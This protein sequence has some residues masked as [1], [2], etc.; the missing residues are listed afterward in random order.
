[1]PQDNTLGAPTEGLGQTVTFAGR[2]GGGVPQ[3]QA[4]QRQAL[5]NNASGGG[6]QLTARA[7]QVPDAQPDP[8]FQVLARLGGEA[9]KPHLEAE[10]TA[11]YVQGMQKAA[12]GQAIQE[13][14]DEQPWFSKLFGSTSLVDGA[15]AYTA[16]AKANSVAVDIESN[17]PELRKLS[18]EEFSKYATSAITKAN[19][20]DA[21][22]D[23][24]LSQQISSTLP[25]V[26]KAQAK[27][28]IRFTQEQYED[29]QES[30]LT[31]GWAG[32]GSVDAAARQPGS[33]TDQRDVG[34][35][36]LQ[37]VQM[38]VKPPEMDAKLHFKLITRTAARA[39]NSGNFAAYRLLKESHKYDELNPEEQGVVERAYSAAS[40]RAKLN[41]PDDVLADVARFSGMADDPQ[42]TEEAIL[43]AAKAI[44][45]RYVQATG[46]YNGLIGNAATV[47]EL[48]QLKANER[49]RVA[50]LAKAAATSKGEDKEILRIQHLDGVAKQFSE[51]DFSSVYRMENKERQDLFD[52]LRLQAQSVPPAE[53]E[54]AEATLN[55]YRASIADVVVD[56]AHKEI[57]ESAIGNAI[58][59]GNADLMATAYGQYYV[60]LLK[61]GGGDKGAVAS[62]YSGEYASFMSKY[63]AI[64]NR[65]G[66]G[67]LWKAAAFDAA[68]QEHT[69]APPAK[70]E[71]EVAS[72]LTTKGFSSLW[73]GHAANLVTGDY[74]VKDP[75]GL[76]RTITAYVPAGVDIEAGVK[77]AKQ[78]APGLSVV[79]GYHWTRTQGATD[80]RV[81]A[82]RSEDFKVGGVNTKNIDKAFDIAVSGLASERNMSNVRVGQMQDT[83]AGQ[84]QFYVVGSNDADEPVI[85]L[86]T[87]SDIKAKWNTGEGRLDKKDFVFGP[88]PTPLVNPKMPNLYTGTQEEWAA[89]RKWQ[90]EQAAKPK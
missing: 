9:I 83:A 48:R 27:E 26:L 34:G 89:Y 47:M 57:V 24:M 33:T 49:Q 17:M 58:R 77:V 8:T 65:T 25:Q 56:T 52:H 36:S 37:T 38:L 81:A 6:A 54:K 15:R 84:P 75:A 41:L 39:I 5:R 51:G 45:D 76:A 87:L 40:A 74:A 2:G 60:P 4:G 62:L 7:L 90:A 28:H 61:A 44:D 80:L 42:V 53:K 88:E 71:A 10:R 18:A 46:D 1:M 20:G 31:S 32:V 35:R 11:A 82:G 23:M 43:A 13:I 21:V 66:E 63:H 79:A 30:A 64:A 69:K 29:A 70:R 19:T 16:A 12:S 78:A 85:A 3:T 72:E 14:V 73:L 59:S 50:A 55:R 86:L 22:T 67:Q 68:V